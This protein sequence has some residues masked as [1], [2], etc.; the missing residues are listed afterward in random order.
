MLVELFP[1]AR[2]VG[3]LYCSAEPNSVYQATEFGKYLDEDGISHKEYTVADSND[4]ASVVQS[5][6]SEVD[7]IYIP[8]DNTMAG[9]T[10]A[11]DNITR[12]AG[13]PVI[14]GEEGICSGC[15]VATLS[16]SY[17]DIGYKAGE[18]AYDILVNGKDIST[19]DIEYARMSQKNTMRISV[20]ISALPFRMITWQSVPNNI[21]PY[22]GFFLMN[23]FMSLDPLVLFSV[24][25]PALSPRAWSG[26]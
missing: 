18:M 20:P 6:V 24:P 7:V 3:I 8:T 13:I 26:G 25:C 5:A 11:V 14:A 23:Y 21:F 12:P 2:N 15:G 17:Y 1:D 10:E 19:M 16:I 22:K 9:N 4:I